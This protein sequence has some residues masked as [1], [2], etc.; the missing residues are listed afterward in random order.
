MVSILVFTNILNDK[1]QALVRRLH[2]GKN[3]ISSFNT[4]N[5]SCHRIS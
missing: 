5:T 1:G 2:T 4:P 3:E